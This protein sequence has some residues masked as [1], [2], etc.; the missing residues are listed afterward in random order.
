MVTFGEMTAVADAHLAEVNR[1]LHTPDVQRQ[2]RDPDLS[3]ELA[4]FAR[5]L[6]RYSDQISTGF[7]VP[8]TDDTAVRDTARRSGALIRLAQQALGRPA[9]TETTATPL[10]EHLRASS[11][12][13]GCGLD[14]L[15]SHFSETTSPT[16]VVIT[17]T[18]TSR[19]LLQMLNKHAVTAAHVAQHLET[20]HAAASKLLLQAASTTDTFN[21][22]IRAP[23]TA[24]PLRQRPER[25]PPAVGE[26]LSPAMAGIDTTAQRLSH[27]DS[28]SSV[29]TWRY[30]SRA[31]AITCD[32]GHLMANQLATRMD[33]LAQRDHAASLRRAAWETRKTALSWRRI[34]RHWSSL[35]SQHGHPSS[36][37]ATDASDLVLRL[38]RIVFATPDWSPGPRTVYRVKPPHVLAP[39]TTDASLV[40]AT[41]LKAIEAC[42]NLAVHHRAAANDAAILHKAQLRRANPGPPAAART[43]LARYETLTAQNRKAVLALG[44]VTL[45]LAPEIMP[46][47]QEVALIL[48]RTTSQGLHAQPAVASA[49]F[50]LSPT[51]ALSS[52]RVDSPSTTPFHRTGTQKAPF[53]QS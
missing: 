14:L 35:T 28:V 50:P 12:A 20:P 1:A 53:N 40:G 3:A 49:D 36:E 26:D 30:V 18:D 46:S 44:E 4:R 41:A 9:E 2:A 22:P 17:A 33:E 39:T 5:V 45:A 52:P 32:I 10:T 43:L 8:D 6:A 11:I 24:V 27:P 7:G 48:R 23:I 42:A 25:I 19:T 51:E 21:R 47:K 37:L 15:T 16:T 13:L 31:A 38:G 34:A 29:T